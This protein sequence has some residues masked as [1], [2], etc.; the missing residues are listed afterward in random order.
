MNR[1]VHFEIPADNLSRAKK[2]YADVFGWKIQPVP[3]MDYTLVTT[4]PS[5]KKGMPRKPGAINGGMMQCKEPLTSPLITIEVDDID[6]AVKNIEKKGGEIA[7]E[8]M[9]VGD[10]GYAAY[11]KDTEGNILGLWQKAKRRGR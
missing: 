11:F 6:D 3:D 7:V 5:D 1:V 8:K 10:M 2:F 4:A 9:P